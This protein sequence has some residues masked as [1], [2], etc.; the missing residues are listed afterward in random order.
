M[1][2]PT[3]RKTTHKH[4]ELRLEMTVLRS[5]TQFMKE[6]TPPISSCGDQP[7]RSERKHCAPAPRR[8]APSAPAVCRLARRRGNRRPHRP[9]LKSNEK[10][11]ERTSTFCSCFVTKRVLCVCVCCVV[12]SCFFY[13]FSVWCRGSF[14]IGS[15]CGFSFQ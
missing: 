3:E 14:L 5:P 13:G 4:K 8:W 11:R 7:L 15:C 10:E 9:R 1:T 12:C 6:N 2:K